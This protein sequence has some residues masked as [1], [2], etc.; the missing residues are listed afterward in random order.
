M[1]RPRRAAS[2]RRP[3]AVRRRPTCPPSAAAISSVS[4]R[5]RG[6]RIA[7]RARPGS[8]SS[9]ATILASRLRPDP[10][11]LAEA[12]LAGGAAAARRRSRSRARRRSR[13]PAR[14]PEP[15][16]AAER[17]QLERRRSA[18]LGQLRDLAGLDELPQPRLDAA[19]D[20]AQ[21]A[22]AALP[23]QRGHRYRSGADELGRTPVRTRAVRIRLRQLEQR[24][25]LVEPAGHQRVVDRRRIVAHRR[26]V[27]SL[28]ARRHRRRAAERG[29][30]RRR[31]GRAGTS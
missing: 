30:T 22:R 18:Q 26:V 19:P 10:G 9:A 11:H 12:A 14:R 7:R 4:A 16:Q 8:C 29:A 20:A 24:R 5:A 1:R 6:S 2:A 15:E 13:A 3:S 28:R 17:H 25:H 21:L 23:D 27:P 31:A